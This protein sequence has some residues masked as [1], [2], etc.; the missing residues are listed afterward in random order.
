MKLNI[1][2]KDKIFT[3]ISYLIFYILMILLFIT[4]KLSLSIIIAFTFCYLLLITILFIYNY[5][6]K[7]KFY[8][9]FLNNLD[10]LDQKYLIT[11]MVEKP[12]F[13]DGEILCDSLYK[14]DKSMLENINIYKENINDFKDYIELWIH[15]IKIPISVVLLIIHNNKDATSE[16]IKEQIKKIESYVEQILYFVRC[17]NAK[18]DYLIKENDLKDIVNQVIV[19]NKD[20]LLT[21]KIKVDLSNLNCKVLTDSK[22][23]EFIIGEILSNSIKYCDKKKAIIKIK[24]VQEDNQVSLFIEDNGIGIEEVELSK[25]FNK[26]FTGTN[27]RNVKTS[28]GMGLFICKQLCTKLAHQIKITSKKG[29]FT[30]VIIIFDNYS[31]YDVVK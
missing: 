19:R 15:S 10:K 3:I 21:K 11:E 2:L 23:L 25:V 6:R 4:F 31:F 29:L 28:T 17:E 9:I 27:G 26:S 7:T 24:A 5:H 16:K 13:L 14:I 20:L 8:N 30:K 22:W 12:N 18:E 1:Y